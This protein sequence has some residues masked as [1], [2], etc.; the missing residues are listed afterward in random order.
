MTA[1]ASGWRGST[2]R[3]GSAAGAPGRSIRRPSAAVMSLIASLTASAW[4]G[5]V[6]RSSLNAASAAAVS[7]ISAMVMTLRP[8]GAGCRLLRAGAATRR[9]PRCGGSA[10]LV[11]GSLA[12][13]A[14]EGVGP[15]S[16]RVVADGDSGYR[17]G[18]GLRVHLL[19]QRRDVILRLLEVE[20]EPADGEPGDVREDEHHA[21]DREP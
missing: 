17:A 1:G 20:P 21:E 19:A 9:R 7:Q 10:G 15:R 13:R 8:V 2:A 5:A 4:S 12:C 3:K 16:D 14:D 6:A 18:A 11:A